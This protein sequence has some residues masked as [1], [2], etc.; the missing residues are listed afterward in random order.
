MPDLDPR[1]YQPQIRLG[2]DGLPLSVRKWFDLLMSR[3]HRDRRIPGDIRMVPGTRIPADRNSTVQICCYGC[4]TGTEGGWEAGTY[5]TINGSGC[6]VCAELDAVRRKIWRSHLGQCTVSVITNSSGPP[7]VPSLLY[8]VSS[9]G[10]GLRFGVSRSRINSWIRNKADP[11][12]WLRRLVRDVELTEQAFARA[13][14]NGSAC[15]EGNLG[16]REGR[17]IES[18]RF[19]IETGPRVSRAPVS[20]EDATY[21]KVRS[22]IAQ[23]LADRRRASST[24]SRNPSAVTAP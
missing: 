22:L 24:K 16:A 4:G 14:P 15:S 21:S 10:R 23:E 18:V 19:D 11:F 12:T 3:A 9:P 7:D 20:L 5:D 13:F 6:P 2:P 17:S 1:W 8:Y